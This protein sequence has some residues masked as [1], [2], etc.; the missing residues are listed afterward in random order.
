ML[1]HF[2]IG[3][4]VALGGPQPCHAEEGLGLAKAVAISILPQG[5]IP[6]HPEPPQGFWGWGRWC[7]A[8]GNTATDRKHRVCVGSARLSQA[9]CPGWSPGPDACRDPTQLWAHL[10]GNAAGAASPLPHS[11]ESEEPREWSQTQQCPSCFPAK[12]LGMEEANPHLTGCPSESLFLEPQSSWGARRGCQFL[13]GGLCPG[14]RSGPQPLT[15]P[16]PHTDHT[17]YTG[18]QST[19][20][21]GN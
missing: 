19:L 20:V 17:A 11:R 6:S 9:L 16:S 18:L 12:S 7:S 14:P 2:G 8:S 4:K 3:L 13:S 21:E 10:G 5:W 15:T 1:Q